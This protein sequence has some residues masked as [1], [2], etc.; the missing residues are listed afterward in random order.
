MMEEGVVEGLEVR[1][2]GRGRLDGAYDDNG[3][4][5]IGCSE[6]EEKKVL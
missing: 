5:C 2:G 6:V 3:S 1:K 4:S